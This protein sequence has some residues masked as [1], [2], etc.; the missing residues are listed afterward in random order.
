ME[1]K[2]VHLKLR[3]YVE[4]RKNHNISLYVKKLFLPIKLILIIYPMFF[5]CLVIFHSLYLSYIHQIWLCKNWLYRLSVFFLLLLLLVGYYYNSNRVIY[6]KF[7]FTNIYNEWSAEKLLFPVY[8]P[9]VSSQYFFIWELLL[10]F[11]TLPT[12]S[13]SGNIKYL[14]NILQIQQCI[15]MLRVDVLN[16]YTTNIINGW[17]GWIMDLWKLNRT[18]TITMSRI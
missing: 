1:L 15:F 10:S 8:T 14:T 6:F 18:K 9:H 17:V 2:I 11:S 12:K 5:C 4:N 3:C 13:S 16:K 7:P